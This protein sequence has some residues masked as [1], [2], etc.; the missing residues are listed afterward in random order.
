M[1]MQAERIKAILGKDCQRSPEN[2]GRYLAYLK[3][4]L[5]PPCILTGTEEFEWEIDY[6]ARGWDDTEYREKKK[7]NPSFLD[8]FDL[9]E[10]L[11]A[12]SGSD[13]IVVRV[14]R[15]EDKKEY[16]PIKG[17]LNNSHA[18]EE[19][20]EQANTQHFRTGFPKPTK[21]MRLV[22]EVYDLSIKVTISSHY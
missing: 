4:K 1:D 16:K 20:F 17:K 15:V 11:E 19:I 18:D 12:D 22:Y 10:L 13:D 8:L 14:K 6:I 9:V 21:R 7:T 5:K 2:A 3:K